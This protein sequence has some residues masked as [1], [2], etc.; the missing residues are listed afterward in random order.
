M[1]GRTDEA[2]AG[3][4]MAAITDVSKHEQRT[5][6]ILYVGAVDDGM[7]QIAASMMILWRLRPFSFLPAS[8]PKRADFGCFDRLTI[9]HVCGGRAFVALYHTRIPDQV[10]VDPLPCAIITMEKP[11]A[12]YAM[13][14][15]YE[16]D[17]ASPPLSSASAIYADD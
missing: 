14:S 6:A 2:E 13:A 7:D 5:I 9:N 4:R 3:A 17:N 11:A 15:L 10:I 16:A 1:E 8:T 12:A